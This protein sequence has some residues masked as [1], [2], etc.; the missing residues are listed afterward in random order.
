MRRTIALAT[1]TTLLT[2]VNFGLA[3]GVGA[4][5]ATAAREAAGKAECEQRKADLCFWDQPDFGGKLSV[6]AAAEQSLTCDDAGRVDRSVWYRK[7]GPKY[8][9]GAWK[10]YLFPE[11]GCKGTPTPLARGKDIAKVSEQS[12]QLSNG[13]PKPPKPETS[14]PPGGCLPCAGVE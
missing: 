8:R 12:V 4:D 9:G 3:A 10:L 6:L 1:G 11:A 13:I 5:R 7:A 2:A 14:A